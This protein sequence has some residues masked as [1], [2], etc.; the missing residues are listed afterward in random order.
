MEA[1]RPLDV[2]W[3]DRFVVCAQVHNAMAYAAGPFLSVY[4]LMC[5]VPEC[6]TVQ[7]PVAESDL[8]VWGRPTFFANGFAARI[9][10]QA[11]SKWIRAARTQQQCE[12]DRSCGRTESQIVSRL[13]HGEA[14]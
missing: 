4:T 11:R 10:T 14:L 3:A 1:P 9:W 5:V 6:L 2:W 12:R 7:N 13:D 8:C